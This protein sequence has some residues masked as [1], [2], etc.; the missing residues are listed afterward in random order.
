MNGIDL[1]LMTCC[2]PAVKLALVNVLLRVVST[3]TM[4]LVDDLALVDQ[5]I[6][7]QSLRSVGTG[8]M[9]LSMSYTFLVLVGL[10]RTA[11]KLLENRGFSAL[12]ASLPTLSHS[13]VFCTCQCTLH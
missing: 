7:L 4:C 5:V 3:F 9:T 11:L 8:V 6:A 12:P 13:V 1:D 10:G 2:Y